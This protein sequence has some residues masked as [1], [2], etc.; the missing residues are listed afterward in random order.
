MKT[1]S[2]SPTTFYL[3]KQKANEIRLWFDYKITKGIVFVQ[4]DEQAL[5]ELGY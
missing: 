3:F 4:A 2:M 5:E 1:I